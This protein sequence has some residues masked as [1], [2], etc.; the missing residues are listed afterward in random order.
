M[1]TY[2][3]FFYTLLFSTG[4]F[5]QIST[6]KPGAWSDVSVWPGNSLPGM[7]DDV[8]LHH[9]IVIDVSGFC[10]S[11]NT[12]G[13]NVTVISGSNLSIGTDAWDSSIVVSITN[14]NY[15]SGGGDSTICIVRNANFNGQKRILTAQ[16]I[17]PNDSDTLYSMFTYNKLGQLI[18][19]SQ[20]TNIPNNS[21][22]NQS[23]NWTNNRVVS[24]RSDEDGDVYRTDNFTYTASGANTIIDMNT[25]P[26]EDT[27]YFG[28]DKSFYTSSHSVTL[29]DLLPIA[30][31]TSFYHSYYYG[32]SND[33]SIISADTVRDAYSYDIDSNVIQ[34]VTITTGE[35]KERTNTTTYKD[36]LTYKFTRSTAGKATINDLLRNIYGND[37]F[38]LMS[39]F[40]LDFSDFDVLGENQGNSVDLEYKYYQRQQLKEATQSERKWE[41]GVLALAVDYELMYKADNVF[42]AQKRI[43]KSS[44]YDYSFIDILAIARY[45]YQ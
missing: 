45:V 12:N 5:A 20:Y 41:N 7:N 1:K 32:W 19:I 3:L 39:S 36:T 33:I 37:L 15:F 30:S 44:I 31:K 34:N 26:S 24:I 35:M 18:S 40:S 4:I 14:V 43:I 27:M 11:L 42:D 16:S 13:H 6:I 28:N 8:V 29:N 2:L 10:R 17:L 21:T 23:I 9:D 38:R 25:I 22:Y